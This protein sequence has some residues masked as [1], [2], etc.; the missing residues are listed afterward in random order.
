VAWRGH[1]CREG[2][3]THQSLLQLPAFAAPHRRAGMVPLPK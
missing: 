1:D 3:Q 2:A